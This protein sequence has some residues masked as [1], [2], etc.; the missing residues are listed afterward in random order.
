[1]SHTKIFYL[2]LFYTRQQKMQ[3]RPPQFF[4]RCDLETLMGSSNSNDWVRISEM[5]LGPVGD[6]FLFVAKHKSNSYTAEVNESNG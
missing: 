6:D 3:Q 4:G 2:N 5:L 1:M